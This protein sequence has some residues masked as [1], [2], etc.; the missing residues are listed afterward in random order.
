MHIQNNLNPLGWNPF[1]EKHFLLTTDH[2]V[3]PARISG[4]FQ[5]LFRVTDGLSRELVAEVSGKFSFESSVKD[6][7]PV[8]GDWVLVKYEEGQDKGIITSLFPRQTEISRIAKTSRKTKGVKGVKQVLAANVD[9]A[10]I[11]VSANQN[12]NLRRIERYF[13]LVSNAGIQP[14]ILMTKSELSDDP[15][16]LLEALRSVV[17]STPIHAVSAYENIGKDNILNYLTPGVTAVL[18]GSSGVGKSTLINWIPGEDRIQTKEISEF[19]DQGTHTTTNRLLISIPDRGM[20]IDTPGIRELTFDAEHG[21]LSETFADIEALEKNC[22]Y[23]NC[24]HY[25]EPGCAVLAAIGNGSLDAGR[26]EN[27]QKIQM[28]SLKNQVPK[29][30]HRDKKR[31]QKDL[32][33]TYRKILKDKQRRTGKY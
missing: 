22:S 7:Y 33:K 8:I 23:R 16:W 25:N 12:F 19:L 2:S 17:F 28:E 32:T 27:Y 5:N 13:T 31:A 1:F 10:F 11:V 29:G 30:H 9:L 18:L 20:I 6:D 21:D 3:F 24:G 14:V 4:T 15:D 26:F